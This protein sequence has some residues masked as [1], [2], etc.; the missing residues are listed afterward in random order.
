MTFLHV[1]HHG[2]MLFN[3]WS[4]VKYVPGGQGMLVRNAAAGKPCVF[5]GVFWAVEVALSVQ[6]G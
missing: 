3:W 6:M 5:C 2:S 4:G 1:Y